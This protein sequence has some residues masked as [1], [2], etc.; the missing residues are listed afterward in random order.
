MLS[1]PSISLRTQHSGALLDGHGG[2]LSRNHAMFASIT[3]PKNASIASA[4]LSNPRSSTGN[5]ASGGSLFTAQ[6]GPVSAGVSLHGPN[7]MAVLITVVIE[8]AALIAEHQHY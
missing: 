7:G 6:D 1:S 5:G 4:L 2:S 8:R 3:I